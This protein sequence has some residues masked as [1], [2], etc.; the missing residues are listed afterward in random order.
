MISFAWTTPALLCGRKTVTRRGWKDSWARGFNRG[1]LVAA[2]DRQPRYGGQ[3]VATIQ[4]EEQPY[5][6]S[7]KLAPW[8]DYEAEGLAYLESIGA[9]VDGLAPKTFWKAWH[10]FPKEMW[11]VR[12]SLIGQPMAEVHQMAME[13]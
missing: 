13:V 9:K 7:T 10:L 1:D 3:Q 8:S 12:F 4:L 2:Y 5:K 11:V 6:E